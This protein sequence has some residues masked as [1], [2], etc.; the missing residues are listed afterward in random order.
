MNKYKNY[1]FLSI[2]E[3]SYSNFTKTN[4]ST[5]LNYCKT[6]FLNLNSGT[7][8]RKDMEDIG[9]IF[10]MLS[11]VYSLDKETSAKFIFEFY[12]LDSDKILLLEKSVRFTNTYFKF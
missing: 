6:I 2:C 9:N 7:V 10:N 11:Q 5:Y 12:S 8:N 4:Y 3:V 1:I